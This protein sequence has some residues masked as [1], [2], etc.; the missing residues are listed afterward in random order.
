M[1]SYLKFTVQSL[2]YLHLGWVKNA[3]DQAFAGKEYQKTVLRHGS[4][5]TLATHS[6]LWNNAS[7]DRLDQQARKHPGH[8]SAELSGLGLLKSPNCSVLFQR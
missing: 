1:T 8:Q 7:V 2:S 3:G 4:S 6:R 5:G